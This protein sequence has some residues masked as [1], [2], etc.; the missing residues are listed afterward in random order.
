MRD[1]PPRFA[2]V[3]LDVDS[4]LSD[5]E[6]IDWLAARRTPELAER[7]RDLTTRAMAGEIPIE[8]VF[9][10][11]LEAVAPSRAELAALG[12]AY[13]ACVEPGAKGALL[14][15]GQAGIRV[16][17][18]SAGLRPAV[19]VL[20]DHLKLSDTQVNAVGVQFDASGN[21]ADFDR[22]SPL[23]RSHGK[24]DLVRSRALPRPILAVGDGITDLEMKT[25]GAVD[26]FAAYTGFVHRSTVVERA[27][28]VVES[29]DAVRA[30]VLG[31]GLT[32]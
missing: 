10:S 5:I 32:V 4:T 20:A 11:R 3:V 9:A 29:F 6:G 21:F 27:D 31:H 12:A 16:E 1:R 14:A 17:L 24:A 7:V 15:L 2:S 8:E 23:A 25:A 30:L 19:S 22:T 26:A 28:H 18:V 13:I